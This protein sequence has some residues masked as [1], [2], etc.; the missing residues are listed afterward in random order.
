MWWQTIG[1]S[2]LYY[3]SSALLQG[4]AKQTGTVSRIPADEIEALVA[5]S[6]R[7]HL[8]EPTEIED[9]ILVHNQ[10][11]RIEVQSDRLVI[12][13]PNAKGVDRK[14]RS[15]NV[16]EVPW[17]KTPSTQR[18]ELLLPIPLRLKK[19]APSG[20]RTAHSW[21][22]RL[23][24]GDVGLMKLMTDPTANTESIAK[25]EDCTV[26]KVNMTI[27]LAFLA[28]DLSRRPSMGLAGDPGP[29]AAAPGPGAAGLP[30]DRGPYRVA[31]IIARRLGLTGALGTVAE[32]VDGVYTGRLVGHMLH[33]PAKGEAIA[34]S[35]SGRGS[36]CPLL[37]VLG[38]RQRPAD[39]AAGRPPVRHQPGRAAARAR[40]APG[41]AD[42]RLPH[43]TQ[44]R[45]RRPRHRGRGPVRR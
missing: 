30:G 3:I 4:R 19:P 17:R 24:A 7:D 41:L 33:G 31:G 39:A 45:P 29:G 8:N 12:E 9:A 34:R 6:V 27:S 1:L 16:I 5:K 11:A 32:H 37:G 10:V 23:H 25:R 40:P 22:H 18:H 14:K 26:R 38:L 44:G 13:L 20:P 42:L 21:L 35:R 43:R 2:L 28:P 36:T 15:R